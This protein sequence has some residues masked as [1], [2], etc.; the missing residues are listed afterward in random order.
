[1]IEVH[2]EVK[3]GAIEFIEI[4]GDLADPEVFKYLAQDLSGTQ[5]EPFELGVILNKYRHEFPKSQEGE[6]SL[7]MAFF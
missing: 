7:L 6:D 1:M 5:H 4:S 2:M 3:K